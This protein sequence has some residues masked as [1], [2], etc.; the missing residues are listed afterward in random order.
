MAEVAPADT[1]L[2][3]RPGTASSRDSEVKRRL[4]DDPA[5]VQLLGVAFSQ[6]PADWYDE[7]RDLLGADPDAAAVV[8]TPDLAETDLGDR[9]LDVESVTTPSNLTGVGVKS[10]PYLSEWSDA[11]VVVESLTVLLQYADP[12]I[13]YRFLHVLTTRL[14]TVDAAGQFFLDPNLLDDQTVELLKTLFDAVVESDGTEEGW[15]VQ[16]RE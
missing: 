7:W 10:T 13:L 12:Q 15:S 2:V 6:P 3:L 4:I 11:V 5:S 16:I 8:T 9:D 14:Q 1:V